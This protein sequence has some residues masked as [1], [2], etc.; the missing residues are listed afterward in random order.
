MAALRPYHKEYGHLQ[1]LQKIISDRSWKDTALTKA[2]LKR[3]DA[4][5]RL[6]LDAEYTIKHNVR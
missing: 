1:S 2:M 4:W 5:E 3:F 6:N